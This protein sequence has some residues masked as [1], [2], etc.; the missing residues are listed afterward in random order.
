M[1]TATAHSENGRERKA[2]NMDFSPAESIAKRDELYGAN[3]TCSH[4]L[5]TI[6][7]PWHA[8]ALFVN[9]RQ[10]WELVHC[11]GRRCDV[12]LVIEEN[13]KLHVTPWRATA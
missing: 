9:S 4:C 3:P 7:E 1:A 13:Q 8:L 5:A 6:Q 2:L 12:D 10:R 11:V